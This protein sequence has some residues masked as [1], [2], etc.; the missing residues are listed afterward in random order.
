MTD[1]TPRTEASQRRRTLHA[2]LRR[3]EPGLSP[4]RPI[5][6]EMEKNLMTWAASLNDETLLSMRDIGPT[7]LRWIRAHQSAYAIGGNAETLVV[8]S[9]PEMPTAALTAP[10]NIYRTT[11]AMVLQQ[12]GWHVE[13]FWNGSAGWFT[14]R[15]VS[16][17]DRDGFATYPGGFLVPFDD[18]IGASGD[19]PAEALRRLGEAVLEWA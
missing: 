16:R 5:T 19:S 12:T 14:A 3:H 2:L 4:F 18:P 11:F 7:A 17:L 15:L 13:V 6:H 10:E 1:Q 9:S 8:R